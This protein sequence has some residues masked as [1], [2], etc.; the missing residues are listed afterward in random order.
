DAPFFSFDTTALAG[1]L[2]KGERLYSMGNPPDLG[3]T[4]SEGTD[5]GLIEHSY[6]EQ[7]HF[8]GALNPGMSGSPNITPQGFFA[9]VTVATRRAGQLI[10]F[11]VPARFAAALAERV[12]DREP[13][14]DLR[15][16]VVRQLTAS[17]T[18][19]YKAFAEKG[20][21]SDAIGPYQAPAT[22]APWFNCW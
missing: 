20:F 12:R 10:S 9:G 7:I 4:I 11:L 6:S 17:R 2:A 15:A 5:N 19:L 16:E 14:S 13:P 18:G 22:A 21:R 8:T 1:N 3:V